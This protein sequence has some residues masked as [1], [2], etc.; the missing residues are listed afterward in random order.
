[1]G[2]SLTRIARRALLED[3]EM[4]RTLMTANRPTLRRLQHTALGTLVAFSSVLAGGCPTDNPEMLLEPM[5]ESEVVDRGSSLDP[6]S[7]SCPEARDSFTAMNDGTYLV[8]VELAVPDQQNP[9][10]TS[11]GYVTIGT[12]FAV[13]P[14]LLATNGHVVDAVL[15]QQPFPVTRVLAVQSG[16]GRVLE[17]LRAMKHPDYTGDPLTSPD[18]GL[19]TTKEEVSTILPLASR[20]EAEAVVLGDEIGLAGFPG[21]VEEFIQ[22]IPGQ[23]VPQATSFVGTITARRSFDRTREVTP[24]TV[25]SFQ[26][27][28]P[29]TPGTSGS[30]I[31]RCGKVIA[32]NNAG[33]VQIIVTVG[34]DGELRAD[35]TAAASNNFGIHVRHL[36]TVVSLFQDDA[37]QGAELP[38]AFEG[39]NQGA[40]N[41]NPPTDAPTN[42][43][44]GGN[45]TAPNGGGNDNAGNPQEEE[46][47]LVTGVYSGGVTGGGA[48]HSFAIELR[49]DA[50]I[51]GVSDWSGNQFQLSGSVNTDDGTLTF[52]DNGDQFGLPVGIYVGRPTANGLVEGTY[53][54]DQVGNVL[55]NWSARLQ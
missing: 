29:T 49:G 32:A 26:H 40:N 34:E 48:D 35:R 9:Q 4:F 39:G 50:S 38:P 36:H 19:F 45:E 31:V 18:V 47:T 44:P 52:V 53:S 46:L 13:G 24:A 1:M 22:T 10:Q 28:A 25:D 8:Q 41:P 21:D 42:E 14:R 3:A 17:L 20:A 15:S 30:A 12:A 43:Q 7:T 51:I 55:G 5:T 23:T 54:E 6:A 11:A 2:T 33:T 37:L 16:T 27:Q